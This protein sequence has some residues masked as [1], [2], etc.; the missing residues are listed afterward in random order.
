MREMALLLRST[1]RLIGRRI[2]QLIAIAAASL[3]AAGAAIKASLAAHNPNGN[4]PTSQAL[5]GAID[6]AK[7]YAKANPGHAVV[8]VLATDGQPDECNPDDASGI[9]ALAAAALAGTPSVK[10]FVIGVFTQGDTT[11]PATVNQIAKAINSTQNLPSW[12]ELAEMKAAISAMR[13]GLL[14][15]LG[16]DHQR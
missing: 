7:A 11:G 16:R 5:A 6:Q 15:A 9:A 8:A 1:P 3:P 13:D 4:T 10:T 12:S 2:G 14:K